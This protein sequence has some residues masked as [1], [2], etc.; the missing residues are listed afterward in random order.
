MNITELYK[1][2]L[3]KTQTASQLFE[4]QGNLLAYQKVQNV[5]DMLP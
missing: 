2:G 4:E 1:S 5:I 3:D